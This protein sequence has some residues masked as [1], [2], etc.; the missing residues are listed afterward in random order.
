[1]R[2]GPPADVRSTQPWKSRVAMWKRSRT[3]DLQPWAFDER[4]RVLIEHPDP[5]RGLEL[6]TAIRRAGFTVGVCT[7]P[8]RTGD[9][10]R[11]CPLHRHEP[12][13]AVE[14]ADVVVTALALE[15]KDGLE[16]VRALRTRYLSTPLVLL[17][18]V[19][20][21]IELGA[22]LTGCTVLAVEAEP[23]E[24]AAAVADALPLGSRRRPG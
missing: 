23:E 1:M 17:A 4:P 8:D 21:A 24:V 19:S 5:D 20:E 15:T 18:T 16:V 12:C 2:F 22:A 14:G 7:G 10:A 13:V 9:P 3:I 11:R 6:G